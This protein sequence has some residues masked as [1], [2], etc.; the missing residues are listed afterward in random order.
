ML[1]LPE[2]AFADSETGNKLDEFQLAD[3]LIG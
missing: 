2:K 3:W 1:G